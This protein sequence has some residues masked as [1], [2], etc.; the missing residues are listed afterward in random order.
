MTFSLETWFIGN[1]TNIT[2]LLNLEGSLSGIVNHK[3]CSKTPGNLIFG[4]MSLSKRDISIHLLN[5]QANRKLKSENL[6]GFSSSRWLLKGDSFPK[7]L[8]SSSRWLDEDPEI[9]EAKPWMPTATLFLPS[10]FLFVWCMCLY[11]FKIFDCSSEVL[12]VVSPILLLWE[13]QG[14]KQSVKQTLAPSFQVNLDHLFIH[15]AVMF[16]LFTGCLA[17]Y[18][19]I[20]NLATYDPNYTFT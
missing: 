14:D 10:F 2:L 8:Q 1:D 17:F 7:N 13:N 3:Y 9:L 12:K 11:W 18:W 19:L 20:W 6:S 4:L 15:L 16:I 5:F